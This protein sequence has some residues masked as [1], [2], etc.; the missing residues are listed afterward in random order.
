MGTRTRKATLDELACQYLD[1]TISVERSIEL[2]SQMSARFGSVKSAK[3][4]SNMREIMNM[5]G[6]KT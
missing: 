2:L 1:P 4:L 6:A 3:A 5:L